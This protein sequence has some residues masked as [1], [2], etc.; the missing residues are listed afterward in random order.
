MKIISCDW[1]TSRFRIRVMD[2]KT[3]ESLGMISTEE[4]AAHLMRAWQAQN[5]LNQVDFFRT[6]LQRQIEQLAAQ[7][8]L[9]TSHLPVFISG[10]ASSS[11]GMLA[12]PYA[13]LPFS[14]DGRDII[15][16]R[17]KDTKDFPHDIHLLSGLASSTDV[18]RG[19]ETQLIGLQNTIRDKSALLILPGTHSKHLRIENGAVQDFSTFMTGEY[20]ALS[21]RQSILS[22]SV[23][24]TSIDNEELLKAFVQGV[25]S[26][27]EFGYLRAL[28]KVRTRTLLGKESDQHNY[29]FLS[30]IH[31]AEEL[32]HLTGLPPETEIVICANASLSTLYRLTL[33]TLGISRP[34]YVVPSALAELATAYGHLALLDQLL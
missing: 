3:L 33:T 7:A 5:Q 20:F 10:M 19:E 2:S 4:G 14:M 26:L 28:F 12:L 11:I 24:A 31:L 9:D 32:Q 8:K 16:H 21:A 18:M 1:G 34:T 17:W 25:E 29:A 15:S 27:A 23:A 6:Y 30:G 13:A 22:H